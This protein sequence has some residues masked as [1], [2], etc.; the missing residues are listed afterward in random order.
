MM[1]SL[2]LFH[3]FSKS[4]VVLILIVVDIELLVKINCVVVN[5]SGKILI[6]CFHSILGLFFSEMSR[7][8]FI[9]FSEICKLLRN[10]NLLEIV[11]TSI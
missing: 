4:I 3:E 7:D 6:C 8:P 10:F 9:P 2:V 11:S 5:S 1:P